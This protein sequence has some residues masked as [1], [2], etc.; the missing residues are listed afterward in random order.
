M[1]AKP[2]LLYISPVIPALTGNGLAMRAGTVLEALAGRYD[3]HLLVVPLYAPVT[4][5]LPEPLEKLCRRAAIVSP[6]PQRRG[7][8]RPAALWGN[9]R[10][11]VVHVFRL[12]TLP[13]SEPYLH[14]LFRRPQ[15]H[16]DLDDIESLTRRRLASL[17]RQNGDS[18][19]AAHEE[20]QAARCESLENAALRRFD[21]VYV[22]SASDRSK[23]EGRTRA[24]VRVLPN[25]VRMPAGVPARIA[26]GVFTFLFVGTLGYYPNEDGVRYLCAEIVPRIRELA[27]SDFVVNIAGT[28]ASES[29][30]Q[31]A[32]VP[33]VRF[34][35]AV[36]DLHPWY[37][38][39]D[40]IV[41][42]IRAGGGTRI[43]ILEAFS[44][45]RPVAATSIAMEGIE[46][47]AEEHFVLGDTAAAFA[48][49]CARLILDG[50][51]RDR[52]ARHALALLQH[53]YTIQS[54]TKALNEMDRRDSR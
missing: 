8:F 45:Q 54:L 23:L 33:Q 5:S 2:R 26:D 49:Q 39:A 53:S 40:A 7:W 11:D 44:Y 48:Q 25:G 4:P 19:M 41:A 18:A 1:P 16:L 21:R 3:V 46:A 17:Y 31:A 10:F 30:R 29:L 50:D 12:A 38:Q 6:W 36:A 15:R 37:A 42:P 34:L 14:G 32:S 9:S 24:D 13:F 51:L 20:S 52:L 28:G 22:C 43:K 35:G 27:G 47:R